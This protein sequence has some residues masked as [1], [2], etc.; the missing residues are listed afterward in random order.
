MVGA[1]RGTRTGTEKQEDFRKTEE[2][3]KEQSV[4]KIANL[5]LPPSSVQSCS[6]T[7]P[8]RRLAPLESFW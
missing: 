5:P 4:H 1:C 8:Q 3:K 7:A 2:N 6:P